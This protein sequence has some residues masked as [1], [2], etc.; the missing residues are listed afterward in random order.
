MALLSI[1]IK[2]YE[3]Y[4]FSTQL[5][6]TFWNT[7]C[8]NSYM[9]VR[10]D[11]LCWHVAS[12]KSS[13]VFNKLTNF[14]PIFHNKKYSVVSDSHEVIKK[15]K[16]KQHAFYEKTTKYVWEALNFTIFWQLFFFSFHLQPVQYITSE[17]DISFFFTKQNQK[18]PST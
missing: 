7:A 11:M 15:K 8:E 5:L 10:L 1:Y 14:S 9:N 17:D 12:I 18:T 4:F 3:S 13:Q 2:L 6:K 16:R